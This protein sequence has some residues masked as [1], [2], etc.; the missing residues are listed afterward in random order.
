MLSLREHA[1]VGASAEHP[2]QRAGHDHGPYL[3]IAEAESLDGVTQLDI[4]AQVVAVLLELVAGCQA[5]AWINVQGQGRDRA[6]DVEPPVPVRT[7]IGGESLHGGH[8]SI[9]TCYSNFGKT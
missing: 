2:L 9:L 8:G 4:H 5:G 6:V 3:R 7:G 1:D